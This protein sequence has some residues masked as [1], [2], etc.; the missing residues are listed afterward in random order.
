MRTRSDAKPKLTKVTHKIIRKQSKKG[1]PNLVNKFKWEKRKNP[2]E[3]ISNI[4]GMSQDSKWIKALARTFI[5]MI[6]KLDSMQIQYCII[7]GMVLGYARYCTNLAWDDDID[8][9]IKKMNIKK[10][11][12]C[13]F[14]K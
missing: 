13:S 5:A 10:I 11:N 2:N 14:G 1:R 8:V 9:M 6:R 3:P 4:L 7:W 12:N